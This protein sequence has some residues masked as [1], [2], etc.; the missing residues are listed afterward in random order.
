VTYQTFLPVIMQGQP[1]VPYPLGVQIENPMAG[2]TQWIIPCRQYQIHIKWRNVET[3]KG[4]YDWSLYDPDFAALAGQRV[5]IGIKIVPEWARLWP[6][7]VASPPKAAYYVDLANFINA[8]IDR[9]HPDAIELFNEPDVDRDVVK[10]YEE[11]F[12]AWCINNDWYT[13]G[14]LYGQCLG[15]IYPIV[16]TSN[17]R[18]ISG[19][20]I[21]ANPSSLTFLQGALDGGLRAD[22]LSFH[23]YIGVDGNYNAAFEFG[24]LARAKTGLPQVLSETSV[25]SPN[26]VDDTDKLKQAQTDYLTFLRQTYVNSTVDVIQW[27]SL[28]NN[29]WR[30]AD[31]IRGGVP[32]PVYDVWK[33]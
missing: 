12:G 4:V 28:A 23:K 1:T 15:A 5:T 24:T 27:F 30:C 33:A 31:L 17:V 29:G 9:Y 2:K 18:I 8:A 11:Y 16:H 13:G 14:K 3:V 26:N 10:V 22:A 32:M 21:G 20:L 19:A 7:Y 6:G 25:L